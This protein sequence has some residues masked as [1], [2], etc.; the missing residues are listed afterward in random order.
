VTQANHPYEKKVFVL[1]TS[2]KE[3]PAALKEKVTIL[4]MIFIIVI[5]ILFEWIHERNYIKYA[6]A[7][8]RIIYPSD[9]VN[10]P[11][12]FKNMQLIFAF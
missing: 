12:S 1:S 10:Y 9:C 6:T 2:I 8:S 4:S 3:I 11:F 5:V 7:I